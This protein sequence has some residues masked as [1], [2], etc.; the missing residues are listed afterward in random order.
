MLRT[1]IEAHMR[2][3]WLA[4]RGTPTR[5]AVYRYYRD[6]GEFGVDAV[7]V[8]LA[9]RLATYGHDLPAGEWRQ[10]VETA[11]RL[12]SAYYCHRETAIDPS[13]LISG[14]DLMEVF[15]L[16]PGRQIGELLA[17]VREEQA[18]GEIHTPE[19]AL[20]RV[21]GWIEAREKPESTA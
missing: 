7:L 11:A 15:H 19:E 17:R 21:Q 1:T 6:T 5:R 12:L 8:S 13:P 3:T 9:D 18:A 4:T 2:P 14:H 20:A 16:L 10:L